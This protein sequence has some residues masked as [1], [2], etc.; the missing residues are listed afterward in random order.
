MVRHEEQVP[1]Q[2]N[3]DNLRAAFGVRAGG[4][5]KLLNAEELIKH[6]YA[7]RLVVTR[8]VPTLEPLDAEG[9][10]ALRVL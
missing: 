5:K 1:E 4:W 9:P 7:H 10:P 2:S 6:S 3:T 8:P